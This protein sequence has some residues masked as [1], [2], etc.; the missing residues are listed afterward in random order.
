MRLHTPLLASAFLISSGFSLAAGPLTGDWITHKA[1]SMV[2]ITEC[3]AGL[4]GQIVWL[5]RGLN[6]GGG[7]VRDK[8]NRD[9]SLRDRQVLGLTTFSDLAPSGPGRWAGLM[10]NPNDGRTYLGSLTLTN[11]GSIQVRGCRVGGGIC[12]RRKWTRPSR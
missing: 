12:G 1:R 8:R 9:R 11:S 5:R 2:R 10:Y 3:G 6:S 7:P 4:C